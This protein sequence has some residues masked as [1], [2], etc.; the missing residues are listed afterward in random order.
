M[1]ALLVAA[2]CI[3]LALRPLPHRARTAIVI[4]QA[5]EPPPPSAV[6]DTQLQAL[7]RGEAGLR[8]AHE[9]MS[10]QY[11]ERPDALERFSAWF[12]SPLYEGLLGCRSW[13][14]LGAISTQE[15][16]CE[17][18]QPDGST[19]F[20]S[21]SVEQVVQVSVKAGRPR[22]ADSGATASRVGQSLPETTYL[23]TLSRQDDDRWTVDQIAPEEPLRIPADVARLRGGALRGALG[24]V[25]IRPCGR[26]H[27][28]GVCRL[29]VAVFPPTYKDS[30]VRLPR[31]RLPGHVASLSLALLR[32]RELNHV[33]V[34]V[35]ASRRFPFF[36]RR[37]A[38][39]GSVE[40]HSSTFLRA[41]APMLTEEQAAQLQP[42]LC[43]LAVREDRRGRGIGAQLV[44]GVCETAAAA[45]RP[46]QHLILQVEGDNTAAVRLYERCGFESSGSANAWCQNK[47][48]RRRLSPP[49]PR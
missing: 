41:Q 15:A 24:G 34:A 29:N 4:A 6:V 26:R 5:D 30:E 44:Q 47:I 14:L 1:R 20:G 11:H 36:F 9:L 39:V 46:G 45:E 23:W 19:F 25:T 42:Y 48:L 37:P 8:S 49:P 22:W 40:V 13:T 27:V 12:G 2:A 17:V 35:D 28:V 10:P 16:A 38:I 21:R 18:P 3:P 31:W 7:Q 43:S 32:R 33:L